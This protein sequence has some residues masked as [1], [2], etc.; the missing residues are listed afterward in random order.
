MD[1]EYQEWWGLDEA[2]NL[3]NQTMDQKEKYDAILPIYKLKPENPKQR[4]SKIIREVAD[5]G[6]KIKYTEPFKTETVQKLFDRR[7][8][9]CGLVIIDES[10]GGDKHLYSIPTL[11]QFMNTPFDELWDWASTPTYRLDRNY[12]DQLEASHIS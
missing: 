3:V 2:G 9:D 1:Y 5:I 8:G 11:H 10:G 7:D 12:K 4:D 6:H